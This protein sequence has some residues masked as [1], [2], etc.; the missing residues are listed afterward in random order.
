MLQVWRE[1]NQENKLLWIISEDQGDEW[2]EGRI[3]L[4]SYD[5]DYQVR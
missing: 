5:M 4:P 2:K 3:I 1:A